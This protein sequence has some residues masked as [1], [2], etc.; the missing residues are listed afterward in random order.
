MMVD[1]LMARNSARNTESQTEADSDDSHL[2]SHVVELS[3]TESEV[4]SLDM[5]EAGPMTIDL[6]SSS[7][8]SGVE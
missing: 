1:I 5:G 4:E 3:D 8:N 6:C 2:E 7:E